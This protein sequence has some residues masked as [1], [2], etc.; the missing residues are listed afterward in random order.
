M[1][2]PSR[3]AAPQVVVPP[4]DAQGSNDAP[5]IGEAI[6]IPAIRL[7]GADFFLAYR[8]THHAYLDAYGFDTEVFRFR[9]NKN[10]TIKSVSVSKLQMDGETATDYQD[11]FHKDDRVTVKSNFA[12]KGGSDCVIVPEGENLVATGKDFAFSYST[13]ES[14]VLRIERRYGERVYV[15]EWRKAGGGQSIISDSKGEGAKGR[16]E[17]DWPRPRRYIERPNDDPSGGADSEFAFF[18]IENGLE[19]RAD[20]VEPQG[21]GLLSNFAA[22]FPQGPSLEAVALLDIALGE[23]RRI[24]PLLARLYLG[25][26]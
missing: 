7:E 9:D 14:G 20:S 16:F 1:A 11:F 3:A 13:P 15:E 26:K 18:D 10:G 24:T 17:G 21:E 5:K 23:D 8:H 12:E 6:V 4:A 19:F 25:A 22:A 2:S